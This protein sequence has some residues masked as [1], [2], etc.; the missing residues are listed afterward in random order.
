MASESLKAR[1]ESGKIFCPQLSDKECEQMSGKVYTDKLGVKR[2][3]EPT[4]HVLSTE[5]WCRS[6]I[7]I[8]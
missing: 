8:Q 5:K 1:L 6:R 3:C 7:V 4:P 2:A